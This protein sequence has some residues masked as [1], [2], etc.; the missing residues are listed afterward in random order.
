M[1][2]LQDTQRLVDYYIKKIMIYNLDMLPESYF[3]PG[4]Q[5]SPFKRLGE[6]NDIAEVVA[7]LAT[8]GSRWITGQN[9]RVNGGTQMM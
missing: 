3:E 7:F 5:L 2:F 1:L 8:E 4:A 6:P 9:I